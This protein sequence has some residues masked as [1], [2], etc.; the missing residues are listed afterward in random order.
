VVV[1]FL[2]QG[3]EDV[4]ALLENYRQVAIGGLTVNLSPAVDRLLGVL[5]QAALPTDLSGV[6]RLIGP[7]QQLLS[8]ASSLFLG[9][10]E[11]LVKSLLAL[12][13]SLYMSLEAPSILAQLDAILGKDQS[14]EN[15]ELMH[16][17]SASW[18]SFLRGQVVLMVI[19][20]VVVTIGGL[21]MGLP[22]AVALGLLAGALEV[23]PNIGPLIATV[24]AVIVAL[25]AGSQ[26]LPVSNVVFAVMVLV[27]YVLVQQLEN[28]IIV[29]KVIGKAVA[30]P[31][32][33]IMVAVIVGAE[34]GGILG[35]IIAAPTL[36]TLREVAAYGLDKVRGIDPYPELRVVHDE[37]A[38]AL[39]QEGIR[40][41]PR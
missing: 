1:G 13:I 32:V 36:A 14:A 10:V 26:V 29:P 33:L 8:A 16:R 21:L 15:R 3:P 18:S 28:S 39:R 5:N 41:P 20:G 40:P 37:A 22:G 19:I 4:A 6:E 7:V 34:V 30:L 38:E 11:L 35:A 23:L 2:R 12:V 27:F 17:I 25:V 9:A 24:P 31:S